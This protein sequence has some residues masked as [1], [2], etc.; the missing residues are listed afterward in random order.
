MAFEGANSLIVHWYLIKPPP[1]D[2]TDALFA[3]R[4][5]KEEFARGGAPQVNFNVLNSEIDYPFS[6]S[7][8]VDS[9]K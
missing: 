1:C 2:L 7:S 5:S 4:V 8:R 6:L 9:F 3:L